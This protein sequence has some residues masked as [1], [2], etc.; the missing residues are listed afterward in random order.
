M[1]STFITLTY[2]DAHLPIDGSLVPSHLQNFIK[3]LRRRIEPFKLRHYSAGEYG[4]Q[5][6]LHKLKNCPHCGPIQ[7]P[8]YHCLIFGW[9]F[10]DRVH[11]GDREGIPVYESQLL[12]ETWPKGLHEI[13]TVTFESASYVAGYIMKKI[14]G[15]KANDHYMRYCPLRD[16]WHQVHP[17][18]HHM[19]KRPGIGKGWIEKNVN[20][21]Y[22]HDEV[23]IPGR[24]VVNGPPNYYDTYAEKIGFDIEKIKQQR[25][26]HME[27]SML[28][29]PSLESRAMV[30]DA[31][32]AR[33]RRNL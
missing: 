31:Q 12:S 30:Q 14:T 8:H 28:E 9:G 21:V 22:P 15:D 18:F 17:E 13:G 32:I 29:G 24:G 20:D 27:Q 7:R 26:H 4:S 1:P 6:I 33:M 19:S 11:I 16:N 2:D 23:P 5:C 10:P 3:R 25:R